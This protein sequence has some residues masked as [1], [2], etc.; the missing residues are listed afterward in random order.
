MTDAT[1]AP[2]PVQAAATVSTPVAPLQTLSA[3][4]LAAQTL[5]QALNAAMKANGQA[6]PKSAAHK[7]SSE[8][9][10]TID[11]DTGLLHEG[12]ATIPYKISSGVFYN[13]VQCF[14]RDLSIVALNAYGMEKQEL[15][16]AQL[17]KKHANLQARL[18][19]EAAEQAAKNNNNNKSVASSSSSSVDSIA[20]PAKKQKTDQNAQSATNGSTFESILSFADAATPAATATPT[21]AAAA[22][23]TAPVSTA[24]SVAAQPQPMRILEALSATG[25]RSVRYHHEMTTYPVHS[26][27][28]NDMDA[29]A[30]TQIESNLIYNGIPLDKCVPTCADACDLMYRHR[31]GLNDGKSGTGPKSKHTTDAQEE[32]EQ[33][34]QTNSNTSSPYSS[35]PPFDVID[36]DPYGTASP[37]I[38]AA[39]Q[40]IAEGGLLCVTCTDKA[41]LC[42]N[43]AETCFGKYGGYSLRS[44]HSAEQAVRLVLGMLNTAAARYRKIITPKLS[45]SIDFYVRV[46]VTVRTSASGAKLAASRMGTVLQCATCETWRIQPLGEVKREVKI[47]RS[48]QEH[49]SLTFA[50]PHLTVPPPFESESE[51]KLDKQ[52]T[53]ADLGKCHICSHLLRHAGPI[54]IGEMHD[55]SFIRHAMAYAQRSQITHPFHTKP[56]IIGMLTSCLNEVALPEAIYFHSLP[57]LCLV[58]RIVQPKAW[59]VR[60]ALMHAGYKVSQSHAATDAIKTNAPHHI[61]WAVMCEIGREQIEARQAKMKQKMELKSA[62]NAAMDVD[63]SVADQPAKTGKRGESAIDPRSAEHII[64]QRFNRLAGFKPDLSYISG[65]DQSATATGVAVY[66]PNPEPNWGPKPMGSRN[67]SSQVG[68]AESP[69][70]AEHNWNAKSKANQGHRVAKAALH[71]QQREATSQAAAAAAAAQSAPKA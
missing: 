20:P 14:N 30:V 2:A 36:L 16:Q 19:R 13:P 17:A 42:G 53:L 4:P 47:S 6:S 25:L 28:V 45:C 10:A 3:K 44:S 34:Q 56:R 12:S 15:H 48:G 60:A 67:K 54:Y 41:I 64:F 22:A 71:R 24:H 61:V 11:S 21:A 40:S 63:K 27:V 62:N 50:A 9:P 8:T 5:N 23:A 37:F 52:M 65:C 1:P 58:L 55:H 57:R 51:P 31:Q 18:Q 49:E 69:S 39:M 43:Y 35:L 26:I 33:A 59:I 7:A 38:D 46:F 68:N 29:D 32:E 70:A 66:L